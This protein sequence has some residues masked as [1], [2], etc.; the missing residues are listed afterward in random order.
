MLN[1]Y[2]QDKNFSNEIASIIINIELLNVPHISKHSTKK[3]PSL[4]IK[5]DI[6][7]NLPT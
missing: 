5:I 6:W 7:F 3:D 2:N 1:F 4:F